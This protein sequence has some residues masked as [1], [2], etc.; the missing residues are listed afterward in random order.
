MRESKEARLAWLVA[1]YGK[2]ATT[3]MAWDMRH[4]CWGPA[5]NKCVVCRA[6][7]R[8][9]RRGR[10]CKACLEKSAT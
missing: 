7:L 3:E 9:G 2:W 4:G 1:Q 10:K 8:P 6:T 5:R